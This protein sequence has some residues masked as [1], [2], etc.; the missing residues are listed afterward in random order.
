MQNVPEQT[1]LVGDG[2]AIMGWMSALT[3]LLTNFVA[4]IAA[5]AS[6]IWACIRIYET[7]TVQN[8]LRGRRGMG[9]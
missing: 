7:K 2:L 8:W 1:K 9:K 6:L 3:G 4:L 5:F